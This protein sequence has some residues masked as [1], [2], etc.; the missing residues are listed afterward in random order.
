MLCVPRRKQLRERTNIEMS[1][2]ILLM[3]EDYVKLPRY[4]FKS[5]KDRISTS[6]GNFPGTLHIRHYADMNL[7]DLKKEFIIEGHALPKQLYVRLPKENIYVPYENYSTK[8]LNS[9][10]AELRDLFIHLKA[11]KIVITKTEIVGNKIGAAAN[12]GSSRIGGVGAGFENETIMQNQFKEELYFDADNKPIDTSFFSRANTSCE[13]YFAHANNYVKPKFYYLPQEYEWED[14]IERRLNNK[15]VQ[16]KYTYYHSD[17]RILKANLMNR[18][19]IFDINIDVE[20]NEQRVLKIEYDIEYH[21]L[22]EHENNPDIVEKENPKEKESEHSF[23]FQFPKL[24]I[25]KKHERKLTQK[26]TKI[27]ERNRSFT[28]M[29]FEVMHI[30]PKVDMNTPS[31]SP[32]DLNDKYIELEV[33]EVI[34]NKNRIMDVSTTMEHKNVEDESEPE[35]E[36]EPEPGPEPG[37]E[38]EPEPTNNTIHEEEIKYVNNVN[39]LFDDDDNENIVLPKP[40]FPEKKEYPNYSDID[41][42]ILPDIPIPIIP[43]PII[44]IIDETPHPKIEEVVVVQKVK[45]KKA[46][47]SNP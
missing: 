44:P 38:P 32:K 19:K 26:K 33:N 7:L 8:Y 20:K 25:G 42:L 31:P 46:K 36:P 1:F 17:T 11:K 14:I 24:E 4:C 41:Q 29:V 27:M 16:D 3:E 9:K 35:P 13:N 43:I 37:P 40:M 10:L 30:Y 6:R 34:T 45:R 47:K 23:I 12:I 21:P 2:L 39:E 28:D 22:V 5:N 18:L 15:L